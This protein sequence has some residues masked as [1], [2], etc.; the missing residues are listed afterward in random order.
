M[1]PR[2]TAAAA[3]RNGRPSWARVVCGLTTT[4][5]R[6]LRTPRSPVFRRAGLLSL[7]PEGLGVEQQRRPALRSCPGRV[8]R[9][10]RRV[11]RTG[12]ESSPTS[13]TSQSA[14]SV[15]S[16][17]R[18]VV[19]PSAEVPAFRS[20]IRCL[21]SLARTD[22]DLVNFLC[23]AGADYSHVEQT[24]LTL[25]NQRARREVGSRVRFRVSSKRN[26]PRPRGSPGAAGVWR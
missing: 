3:R 21:A 6:M 20:R 4:R 15:V 25:C 2:R 1:T 19:R 5:D 11:I 23:Q 14:Q 12:R 24:L 10:V 26:V 7:V 13:E 18:F 9:L 17:R 22:P 16:W 8:W